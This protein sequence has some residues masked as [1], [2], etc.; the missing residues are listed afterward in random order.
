MK[1]RRFVKDSML[2]AAAMMAPLQTPFRTGRAKTKLQPQPLF[3][4]APVLP[5]YLYEHGMAETLDA[6]KEVS[7]IETVM[8]FSHDFQFRQYQPEFR[9]K[10]D[11]EGHAL[12]NIW[13]G[14]DERF[15]QDPDHAK[16]DSRLRYSDRDVLDELW[17]EAEPRGM[18]VYARILEP[19]VITGAIPGFQSFAE[20]DVNGNQGSNVCFNHPGYQAYWTSVAEDL[21]RSHP[22]LHGFKFGQERGGP[23]LTSLGGTPGTCFCE[24]CL[25]VARDREIHISRAREGL[26]VLEEFGNSVRQGSEVPPD[27]YFVSLFRILAAYP[28]ILSWEKLWMD[29]REDQKKLIYATIKEIDPDILVGWHMDHGMTWDLVTRTFWDYARMGPYSDWLSVALYFDSMGRRSLNHYNKF[30]RQLIFGDADPELSYPMY[31]SLLG[32]PPE[33]QPPLTA[34]ETEDTAFTSDYVF[35]ECERVVRNV[36]G[37]ARVDARLGF[38]MPGYD[39]NVTPEQV[40]DAVTAALR[41]GVDG[42]W[43]GRE[44]NEISPS[45]AVAFG[46][47]VRDHR[48]GT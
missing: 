16:R 7:G 26:M 25:Q 30:Y 36:G 23:L 1:R 3:T 22:Y 4:G 44:W 9:P 46:N 20:V 43:C 21:V 35:R 33:K 19:Y 8:T 14:T 38:D 27:G 45:N 2:G 48:N 34:H 40:Y 31:L 42:L 11:S 13:V 6:M 37:S 17:A 32:Y 18:K 29:S 47:A 39:C 10:T 41:A 5:E 28:E 12:T 15:Y 24:Y